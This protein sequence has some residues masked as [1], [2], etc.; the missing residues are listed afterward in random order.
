[1]SLH[2]C[3]DNGCPYFTQASPKSCACHK[4]N[5][6]VLREQVGDLMDA[7]ERA[8]NYIANTESELGITLDSGDTLRAAIAKARG[9]VA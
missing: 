5:E 3:N 9:E 6:Q 7:A 2:R 8:L 4:A 1:M